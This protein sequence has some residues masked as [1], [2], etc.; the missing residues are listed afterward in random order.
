[1][2]FS[3]SLWCANPDA[4]AGVTKRVLED[5]KKRFDAAGIEIPYPYQNVL[6]KEVRKALQPEGFGGA[7]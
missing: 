2:D 5:V 7:K 3:L 6:I 4:A 1:M